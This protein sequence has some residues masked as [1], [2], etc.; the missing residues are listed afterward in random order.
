MKKIYLILAIV[1]S[2]Y[3]SI[4]S[5]ALANENNKSFN[6]FP[7]AGVGLNRLNFKRPDG[8][9][10][11]A[12]YATLNVGMT[13]RYR[14]FYLDV[15][16]ELFGVDFLED[17]GDITGIE[18]QDYTGTFGVTPFK[19]TSIFTGYTVGEMKDDFLGEFYDD[20]GYFFGAGY[21]HNIGI[22]TLG[23]TMAYADLDG[24]KTVDGDPS[25]NTKGQTNGYSYSFSLSGPFRQT[26]AY[27]IA[28]KTRQYE[29]EDTSNQVTDKKIT[30]LSFNLIF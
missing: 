25:L 9:E 13:A 3:I 14:M 17:E 18:R 29:Y 30:S 16:G 26:M 5:P 24:S 4:T 28:L 6:I 1:V 10:L 8:S 12:S 23:F 20:R 21:S 19:G 27:S 11:D 2:S 7:R 22:S 15:G